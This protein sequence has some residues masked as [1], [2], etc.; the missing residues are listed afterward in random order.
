MR[1]LR[2]ELSLG[3]PEGEI[4]LQEEQLIYNLHSAVI[5]QLIR[6][7][8]YNMPQPLD[9]ARVIGAHVDLFLDA[10]PLVLHRLQAEA[11]DA[12]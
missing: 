8:V 2:E 9:M 1:E 4:T 6:S 12:K 11:A 5:Y 7:H 10:V 3:D